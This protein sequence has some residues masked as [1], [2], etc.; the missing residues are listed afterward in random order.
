MTENELAK[1]VFE[2]G[3]NIHKALGPGLLES[4]YRECL[5]YELCKHGLKVEKHKPFPLEY[6]EVKLDVGYHIDLLIEG[7]LIVEVK[8]VE[9][10]NELHPAQLLTYLKLSKCKLGMLTNFN[11]ILF[12]D[13]VKRV[14]NG[15]LDDG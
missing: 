12:K 5:Y 9:T 4:A 3:L 10:F 13:G 7:K 8:A 11:T 2:S 15:T 6:D 14:I 1:I